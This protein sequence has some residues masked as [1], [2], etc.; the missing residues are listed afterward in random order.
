MAHRS[1]DAAVSRDERLRAPTVQATAG[2]SARARRPTGR[3]SPA[4]M[5]PIA[6]A[7]REFRWS[8]PMMSRNSPPG[9]RPAL[10]PTFLGSRA[11]RGRTLWGGGDGRKL[12]ARY[13]GLDGETGL[14]VLQVNAVVMPPLVAEVGRELTEGQ[15]VQIFAPERTTPEGEGSSRNIYVKV[16]EVNAKVAAPALGAG[17]PERLTVRSV[18]LS[19]LVIGGVACDEAGKTLHFSLNVLP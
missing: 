14:S 3:L 16:G 12:R 19:P 18:R 7:D 6:A 10:R 15:G 11:A 9:G 13:V 5:K 17:K 1:P 4:A 2:R 8:S